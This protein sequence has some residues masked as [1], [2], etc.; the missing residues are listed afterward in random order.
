MSK[1]RYG[2]HPA[3]GD[4]EVYGE[5]TRLALGNFKISGRRFPRA[6]VCAPGLI[7]G[8]AAADVPGLR[9]RLTIR[10]DER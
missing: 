1:T 9:F 4:Q 7:K 8:C 6:F 5:Q 2:E 10:G 3:V